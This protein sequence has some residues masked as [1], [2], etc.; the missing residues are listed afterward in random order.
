MNRNLRRSKTRRVR[1]YSSGRCAHLSKTIEVRN[2]R[3]NRC[4]ADRL[5]VDVTAPAKVES[6][7]AGKAFVGH[8][9]RHR[10][11]STGQ[12]NKHAKWGICRRYSRPPD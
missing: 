11:P 8:S 5:E 7:H 6:S 9:R 3:P 4:A 12:I 2:Y 1:I 10:F